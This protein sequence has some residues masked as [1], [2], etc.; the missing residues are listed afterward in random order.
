MQ[1]RPQYSLSV[2]CGGVFKYKKRRRKFLLA[3]RVHPKQPCNTSESEE[4]EGKSALVE[5]HD[6]YCR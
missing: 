3:S 5:L 4:V 6:L 2:D 1:A